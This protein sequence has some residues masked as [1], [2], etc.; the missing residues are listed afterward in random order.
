MP[1]GNLINKDTLTII[2]ASLIASINPGITPAKKRSTIDISVITPNKINVILGGIKRA[3]PP[4]EAITPAAIHTGYPLFT[5]S[6]YAITLIAAAIAVD[7]PEIAPN[8]TADNR[9]A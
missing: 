3:I 5:S 9:V 8:K 6:G 1:L 4:A 7:E 2:T